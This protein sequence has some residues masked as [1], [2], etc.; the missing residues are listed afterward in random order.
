[1][2]TPGELHDKLSI[3]K[4][5]ETR[6]P[7]P[8]ARLEIQRQINIQTAELRLLKERVR[9]GLWPVEMLRM[10][11]LKLRARTADRYNPSYSL[12]ACA[13]GLGEINH[14]MWVNEE[15]RDKLVTAGRATK[16]LLAADMTEQQLNQNR[17][18]LI[19]AINE[20]AIKEWAP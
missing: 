13:K 4:L 20:A 6:H 5:R 10:P 17:N 11:K 16:A 19:D 1:M 2:E 18:A 7:D 9:A 8:V 3:L 14:S 15:L 12:A